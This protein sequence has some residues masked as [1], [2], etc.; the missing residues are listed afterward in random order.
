MLPDT[1]QNTSYLCQGQ[2]TMQEGAGLRDCYSQY[3]LVTIHNLYMSLSTKHGIRES[4]DTIKNQDTSW[5][6]S[7]H[8]YMGLGHG[9]IVRHIYSSLKLTPTK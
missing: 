3:C 5:H 1:V 2:S 9:P 7:S 6:N 4:S 8:I